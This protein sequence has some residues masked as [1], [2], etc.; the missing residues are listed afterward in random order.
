MEIIF[1]YVYYW[2]S[3]HCEICELLTKS[4]YGLQIERER[5][6]KSEIPIGMTISTLK[7]KKTALIFC[8]NSVTNLD[9]FQW[10]N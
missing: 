3:F 4:I 5:E 9:E 8:I 10:Y 2:T 6:R 7:M 1:E